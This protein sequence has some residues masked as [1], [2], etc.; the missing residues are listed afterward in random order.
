MVRLLKEGRRYIKQRIFNWYQQKDGIMN[1]YK[2]FY[3]GKELEIYADSLYSAK[4]K[5]IELFKPLKSKAHMVSVVLCELDDKQVV[6]IPV[7]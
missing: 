3:N 1:G 6:H 2:A 7:D 4:L 5:A